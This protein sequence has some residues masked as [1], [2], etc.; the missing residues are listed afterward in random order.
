M[1]DKIKILYVA[2]RGRSG[3]TILDNIL[4]QLEGFFSAGELRNITPIGLIE[5][6][7]CGCGVPFS[8]CGLWSDI[9]GESFGNGGPPVNADLVRLLGRYPRISDTPL[10]FLPGSDSITKAV[11]ADYLHNLER[12]YRGIL[13]QTGCKVIVD[14]S[15]FPPYGRLLELIPSVDLY[16]VHLVRDARAVAYSWLRKQRLPSG[17][18]KEYMRQENS[19]RSSLSWDLWN[20]MAELFWK[21]N[22]DRYI[23]MRYEDFIERPQQSLHRI[24]KLVDEERPDLPL[25]ADR[26]VQLKINH[27]VAGNPSRFRTG[28]V[29]LRANYDW[30]LKMHKSDVKIVTAMSWPLLYRYGYL[31]T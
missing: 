17:N 10:F 3:S 26:K 7:L 19:F 8:E 12:L 1:T 27:T 4:G 31:E 9:L 6:R 11:F 21:S 29:D 30:K 14:S 13:K 24:L 23:M 2:G 25:L 20:V 18:S 15:K 28:V 16:V 5:N 22:P